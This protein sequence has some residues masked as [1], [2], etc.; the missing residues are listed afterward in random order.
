MKE[1]NLSDKR[2]GTKSFPYY[3]EEDVKEFI[4]ILKPNFCPE[5]GKKFGKCEC[6]IPVFTFN[7]I[8]NRINKF[9]GEKLK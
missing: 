9:S 4:K 8:I 5:C 1:F 3:D 2:R 7:W 6:Y